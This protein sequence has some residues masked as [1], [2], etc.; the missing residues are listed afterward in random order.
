MKTRNL[1]ADEVRALGLN[2]EE[3]QIFKIDRIFDIDGVEIVPLYNVNFDERE[4]KYYID[5]VLEFIKIDNEYLR[6]YKGCSDKTYS[7]CCPFDAD[8]NQTEYTP[9][10]SPQKIGVPTIKKL[11]EWKD[12][13][14][15]ERENI[16]KKRAEIDAKIEAFLKEIE[17]LQYC[18]IDNAGTYKYKFSGVYVRNG[19]KYTY[20]IDERTGYISENIDIH[21]KVRAGINSFINLSTNNYKL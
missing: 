16:N 3:C 15:I 14:I 21:Y 8:Y 17:K 10:P 20:L 5:S 12:Y 18:R 19:I 2:P 7:F 11:R 1:T 9:L 4:E 6:P 13:L